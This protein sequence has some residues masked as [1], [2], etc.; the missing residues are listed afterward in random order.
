MLVTLLFYVNI[1][2]NMFDFTDCLKKKIRTKKYFQ[3]FNGLKVSSGTMKQENDHFYPTKNAN[4]RFYVK[5]FSMSQLGRSK[6]VSRQSTGG[7]ER[8]SQ[9]VR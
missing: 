4:Q 8:S 2:S 3:N 6:E 7:P 1:Q 5:G 9:T